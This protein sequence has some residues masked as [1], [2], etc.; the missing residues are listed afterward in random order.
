MFF[1]NIGLPLNNGEKKSLLCENLPLFLY[2]SHVPWFSIWDDGIQDWV[3]KT[4]TYW[5]QLNYL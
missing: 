3:I 4:L 5:L 1:S 2:I